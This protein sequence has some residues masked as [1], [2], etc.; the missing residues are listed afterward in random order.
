[1]TRR[2]LLV[3]VLGLALLMVGIFYLD[4]FRANLIEERISSLVVQGKIIARAVAEEAAGNED[5]P[6]LDPIAAKDAMLRLVELNRTEAQLWLDNKGPITS[7]KSYAFNGQ[8]ISGPLPP[9]ERGFKELIGRAYDALIAFLPAGPSRIKIEPVHGRF[10]LLPQINAAL[11]GQTSSSVRRSV[12]GDL[13][14]YVA[15][16]VQ[17]YHL[18]LGAMLFE[19]RAGDIEGWVRDDRIEIIE[20]FMFVLAVTVI[21]SLLMAATIARPIRR[22]AEAANRLDPARA[23]RVEI[24]DLANRHD[25]IGDLSASLRAMTDALLR[26]ID[27][28]ESF[29]ADV[30]HEI[31]NPLTSLRSAVET[32]RRV[33]NEEQRARLLE[34]ILEDVGRIDRLISDISSASRLDAELSRAI[35][36]EVDLGR[37]METLLQVYTDMASSHGRSLTLKL[38]GGVFGRDGLILAE[39][40]ESRLGQVMRNLIDNA[41]SFSPP[42]GKV[43]LTARRRAGWIDLIVEDEGPGIPEESLDR[44]FERFYSERPEGESF[45]AHSG[46]GLSIARQIV[47]AHKGTIRAENIKDA[48]G[49]IKGARFIVSLPV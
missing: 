49:G 21:L 10:R 41:I 6:T 26:R 19:T 5:N 8:V 25:E 18:V 42:H 11:A 28:I 35:S 7:T 32:L 14:V 1:M 37:L 15:V 33:N 17:S 27:A 12:T 30:A 29:A 4:Q 23:K 47:E 9:Q 34:V 40:L 43:T 46:L 13:I 3:N 44:I 22:L 38:D 36:V 16:P 39:G 45:G 20:I 31:K 48:A 24:P 2:I